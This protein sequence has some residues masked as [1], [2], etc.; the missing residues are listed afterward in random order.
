[1]WLVY[2]HTNKINNKSYIGIT[3]KRPE[4][5][6]GNNGNHYHNHPKFYPAIKKYGWENFSHEILYTGL[7]KK[8]ACKKEKELIKFYNSYNNGYNASLG[9]ECGSNRMYKRIKK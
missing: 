3:S 5:R 2:K 7:S 4:Q 9:G 6:W 8:E 1:M